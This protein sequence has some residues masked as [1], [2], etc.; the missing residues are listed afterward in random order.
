[1]AQLVAYLFR[2][3]EVKGSNPFA[4]S[5]LTILV[6]G[7]FIIKRSI[8]DKTKA[9]KLVETKTEGEYLF[10]TAESWMPIY[11]NYDDGSNTIVSFDSDGFGSPIF[12][13]DIIKDLNPNNPPCT[14]SVKK[15]F[16]KENVGLIVVL[17]NVENEKESK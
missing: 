11:F 2:N 15:I 13:G 10:V 16:W 9:H 17:E 1:M 6:M 14:K 4:G 8:Y 3:Q 5:F 12:V 7:E